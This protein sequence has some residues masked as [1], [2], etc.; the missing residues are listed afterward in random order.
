[1]KNSTLD[2]LFTS[3]LGIGTPVNSTVDL[4]AWTRQRNDKLKVH[5][6]RTKLSQSDFW[7]YDAN[8]GKITN[9]NR[10]FFSIEGLQC[11][12]TKQPIIIQNEIGYL[13]IICRQINGLLHFLI[14][15]KI[16]PGNVNKV[17]L[18]PTIQ[19]TKSNFTQMHGGKRPNYIDYFLEADKY[20]IIVDQIQSEQSSRFYGKR[21]RNIIIKVEENVEVLPSHKWMTLKQIKEL[22]RYDNLVNMDTRTVLSCIPFSFAGYDTKLEEK[23]IDKALYRSITQGCERNLLP[24]IYRYINN[25]KM[26]DMPE[27]KL[28]PLN[29]M[30]GWVI[31]DEEI[32]CTTPYSFK[33]IYCDISIEEREV[34]QWFQPLFEACGKAVF[35]LITKEKNGI[36]LFLVKA[37]SEVGCFDGIELG[38][39]I[40]HEASALIPSQFDDL[41]ALFF[42]RWQR[43]EGIV[44]NTLL[45]EEGGRFYHEQ[46][47]NVI[48]KIETDMLE[49]PPSGYFWA[50][51][52]TLN[53]LTQVNNCLNIQLRNLL[54][55]LET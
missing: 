29:Q 27:R 53:M 39:T 32:C 2:A 6:N 30:D 45:S 13:G 17:Q 47:H 42:D 54:S 14:Q 51:F 22:M 33:V 36:I 34:S 9:N 40:Q 55:V 49:D 48:I 21:N 3:W 7:Y 8:N 35:G 28:I 11:G 15:A 16:E 41:E 52:K 23:F 10:C 12:L 19:A 50:D 20:E 38:P 46:N 4:L 18:S 1:M 24:E 43:R 25:Y 37:I 26:L 31:N 44:F 5:I